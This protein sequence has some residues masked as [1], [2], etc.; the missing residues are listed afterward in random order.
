[1][2]RL[3]QAYCKLG[4]LD[5]A[6]QWAASSAEL[7]A[8]DDATTQMLWRQARAKVLALRGEHAD[9]ERLA[10]EAIEIGERTESPNGQA[11]TYADFGEVLALADR[12]HDAVEALE[13]ALSRYEAKEN[14]VMAGRMRE[15]LAALRA[16][17]G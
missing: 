13:Q 11:D 8:S 6:E 1:V 12:P 15:R 2:G 5:E 16:E 14:L 9:A 3:A 4:Q 7:G 17:V 10:R